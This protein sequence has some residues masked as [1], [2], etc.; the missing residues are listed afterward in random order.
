MLRQRR[1]KLTL[2][3]CRKGVFARMPM[4]YFFSPG[5]DAV[6][7]PLPATLGDPRSGAVLL[8]G[9]SFVSLF[10]VYLGLFLR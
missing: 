1:K 3:D 5:G 9:V 2:A 7:S 6:I 4:T 8:P 10:H